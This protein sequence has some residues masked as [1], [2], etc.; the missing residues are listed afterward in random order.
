[1]AEHLKD[2]FN[3]LNCREKQLMELNDLIE[4]SNNKIQNTINPNSTTT[5]RTTNMMNNNYNALINQL[6]TNNNN[7]VLD[8]TNKYSSKY[9]PYDSLFSLS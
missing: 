9:K 7:N 2:Y 6:S 4:Q 3:N 1:M 5:C 8:T